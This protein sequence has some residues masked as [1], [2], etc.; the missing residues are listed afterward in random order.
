MNQD[1]RGRFTANNTAALIHGGRSRQV[2]AG[3]LAVQ[4]EALA[5]MAE[6][7]QAIVSDLGGE[8]SALQRNLITDYLRVGLV[9][10][11][12]FQNL[13]ESGVF[14][15]H[16]KQRA[17]VSTLMKAIAQRADL[18][19]TLGLQRKTKPIRDLNTYLAERERA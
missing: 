12:A 2:R 18:A 15:G 9:A 10:D 14:T 6:A 17:I 11:F 19:K 13:Q 1:D 16:G 4:A 5:A 8:I 7:H 3:T